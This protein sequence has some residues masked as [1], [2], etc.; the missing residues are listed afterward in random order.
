MLREV[1]Y[2]PIKAESLSEISINYLTDD[3]SLAAAGG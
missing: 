3:L 2:L 1:S